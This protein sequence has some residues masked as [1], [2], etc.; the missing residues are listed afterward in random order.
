M[1]RDWHERHKMPENAT[2]QERIK[3]HLEHANQCG[4][5]PIPQGLLA[6]MSEDAKRPLSR[7]PSQPE[8]HSLR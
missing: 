2:T 5:R 3:W 6:R 1:N 4:C 7:H 8:L